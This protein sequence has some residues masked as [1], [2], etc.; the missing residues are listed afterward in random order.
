MNNRPDSKQRQL[1][2]EQGGDLIPTT[3]PTT[4]ESTPT[5]QQRGWAAR[6][7]NERPKWP[8]GRHYGPLPEDLETLAS[9]DQANVAGFNTVT[10]STWALAQA[11]GLGPDE[12]HRLDGV[13]GLI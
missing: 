5:K 8:P 9:I 3:L 10:S 6:Y 1:L 4:P 7:A 2:A 12:L 13:E 11:L